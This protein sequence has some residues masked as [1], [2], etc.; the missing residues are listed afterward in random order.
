ML[1]AWLA[2]VEDQVVA[3]PFGAWADPERAASLVVP[4]PPDAV[5]RALLATGPTPA[6][7]GWAAAWRDAE[8]AAQG[9]ID[10]VL[11]SHAEATEPGVARTVTAALGAGDTVFAANSM[12]VRDVE[13]YGSPHMACRVAAN[14]G[15]N[16]IDG[17]VSTTL[18]LAAGSGGRTVGLLGDLAFVHDSGGLLW[19]TRRGVRCCFVVVDNDG[20]GIFSFLPQADL[21]ADRFERLFGTPH[22]IDLAALA[23]VH[24]IAAT[25]VDRA[26]GVGPALRER[27]A[28]GG[29]GLVVV[30]TDRAGNVAV[31]DELVG[32][33]AEALDHLA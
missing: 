19:A 28:R 5:C 21:D 14:R 32:A 24:G 6:P 26:A 17:L 10:G 1:A 27:L 30:R 8:G 31:H 2:A 12:P 15:A 22:G 7:H 33:V 18:G 4:A 29:V 9:A 25:V 13:W 11:S 3:D 16:G 20:G 23:A